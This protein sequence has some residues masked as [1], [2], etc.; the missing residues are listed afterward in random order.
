SAERSAAGC[1]VTLSE[2]S[3]AEYLKSNI[4][5]L[6]WMIS[7]GYGDPRTLERRAQ[8]MEAW[9]ADPKLMRA[10]A[11]AEYAHIVEINLDEIKEPIVCC[12]ND[13]DDAKTLS[14]V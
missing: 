2:E 10:D 6:R 12:P 8:A 13:P 1:T 14:D 5:M 11:D 9:L 3:V 4:V 7:E